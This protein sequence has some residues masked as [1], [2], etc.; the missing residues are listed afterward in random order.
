MATTTPTPTLPGD[1]EDEVYIWRHEQFRE[2]GF[3]RLDA[4]EL[5][6]SEADLGQARYLLASG[7]SPELAVRILR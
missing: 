3:N 2:L 1:E 4:S 7:C 5:A 6:V